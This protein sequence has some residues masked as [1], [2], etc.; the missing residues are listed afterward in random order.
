MQGKWKWY[1]TITAIREWMALTGRR[2]PLEDN[3]PDFVAAEAELGEL[4]LTA[5]LALAASEREKNG[6]AYASTWAVKP[7]SLSFR[8]LIRTPMRPPIA[9]PAS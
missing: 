1:I 4:S 7:L 2:G 3:N 8:V 6:F 9:R 5:H